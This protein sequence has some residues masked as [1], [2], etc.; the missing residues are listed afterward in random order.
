[1]WE[2][3]GPERCKLIEDIRKKSPVMNFKVETGFV[4][5]SHDFFEYEPD[6]L[7]EEWVD[8]GVDDFSVFVPGVFFQDDLVLNEEVWHVV[9][10]VNVL[11]DRI[12]TH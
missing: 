2:D 9:V 3:S 11:G 10:E 12:K 6:W 5:K 1:M 8:K 4:G 7:D